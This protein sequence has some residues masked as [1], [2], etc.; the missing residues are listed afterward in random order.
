MGIEEDGVTQHSIAQG[1]K[2]EDISVRD[3]VRKRREAWLAN[4]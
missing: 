3:Q 1:R 2:N 4:W